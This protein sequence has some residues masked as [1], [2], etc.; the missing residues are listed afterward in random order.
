MWP[1]CPIHGS[2]HF[3][4]THALFETHSVLTM[5]SGLQ[6]G[7]LPLYSGKQVQTDWSFITLHTLLGPHGDGEHGFFGASISVKNIFAE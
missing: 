7:G 2:T 6:L 4:L 3:K 1:H 5:H